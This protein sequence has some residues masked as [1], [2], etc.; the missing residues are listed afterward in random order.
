[1]NT[2][3][4]GIYKI[5]NTINNNFY[6]G[7]ALNI[8]KRWNIHISDLRRGKH[9]SEHLQNAFNKYGESA[10]EFSVI[11]ICN[12]YELILMEQKWI[13][14]LNPKYNMCPKA[15]SPLGT[16]HGKETRAKIGLYHKGK[17]ISEDQRK[18]IS[19]AVRGDNNP[20]ANLSN[21]DV[22][23]IRHLWDSGMSPKDLSLK[24]DASKSTINA[25]ISGKSWSH[26]PLCR[27]PPSNRGSHL[28]DKDIQEIKRL[29]S[30][31][32]LPQ[33]FIGKMFR[34][35]QAQVSRIIRGESWT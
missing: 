11:E 27:K 34:I 29:G 2:N 28:S 15:G 13:D 19:Y 9:H 3:I 31:G 4:S 25:I 6:I 16:K 1:M 32:R 30:L 14:E 22:I 5:K 24:F 21:S 20:R 26:L 23:Q 7:S 35:K 17:I 10:F 8:R 33:E 18:K 12:K